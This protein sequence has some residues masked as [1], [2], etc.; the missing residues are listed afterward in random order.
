LRDLPPRES[1]AATEASL[2]ARRGD[3]H[4]I[5]DAYREWLSS[6]YRPPAA[7]PWWRKTFAFVTLLAHYDGSPDPRVR[8]AIEPGVKRARQYLGACDYAHLFGWSSSPKWGDWG[9]YDHYDE[10]VGGLEYFRGNIARSQASGVPV[11]LYIDGY[12]NGEQGEATGAHAR[13]WAMA[14]ADGAPN[15]IPEYRAYNECPYLPA[16]QAYLSGVYGRVKRDLKPMGL[17]VDEYG[18]TDTRWMCYSTAH[19]HNGYEV[20]YA[21][22]AAM[23]RRI[24]AAVGPETALYSEYPPAEVSRQFL[25]GSFTYQALWSLDQE[26]LAPHFID[27]PRFAFPAFKQ[28]HIIH[29]VP[30]RAGNWWIYKMPFFNGEGHNLGEPNLPTYDAASIAFL[31]RLIAVQRAHRD[32]FASDEVS[33]LVPTLVPGVYAN[34]FRTRPETVWTIYNANPRSVRSAVLRVPHRAGARY[35]DA[36]AGRPL[37]PVVRGG[38]AFLAVELGPKGLGCIVQRR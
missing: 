29:Y 31:R 36:W 38:E 13:D 21:G 2:Q 11:G 33:P 5:F 17:Y 16:W 8:G 3:W 30:L 6:W 14:R 15:Y 27:L 20:P 4:A 9:D 32:A 22:E 28:F 10:T 12:L 26:R 35:L 18:A 23:L 7:K 37:H 25:D 24:R 1:F 19:G 34:E